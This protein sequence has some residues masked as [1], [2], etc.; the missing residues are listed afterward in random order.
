MI[1]VLKYAFPRGCLLL[2]MTGQIVATKRLLL[3]E[4]VWELIPGPFL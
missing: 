1:F 4:G 3:R 2:S